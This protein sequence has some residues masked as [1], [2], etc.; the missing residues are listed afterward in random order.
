MTQ[1]PPSFPITHLLPPPTVITARAATARSLVTINTITSEN[2]ELSSNPYDNRVEISLPYRKCNHPAQGLDLKMCPQRNLPRLKQCMNGTPAAHISRWK[3]TLC[4]GYILA[5]NNT[6]VSTVED[7]TRAIEKAVSTKI[8]LTIVFGTLERSS[9]HPQNGTPIIYFDHLLL[10]GQH[11][12][13]MKENE[14]WSNETSN[15]AMNKY[16]DRYSVLQ[17][18]KVHSMTPILPKN[19]SHKH[20]LT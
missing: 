16:L 3:S 4:S 18:K 9:L 7:A 19:K 13:D 14:W 5:V 8:D 6:T 20:K 10:T 1:S 15:D 11:L 12:N 17:E 2:L